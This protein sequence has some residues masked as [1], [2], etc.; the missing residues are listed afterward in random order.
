MG[1]SFKVL[2]ATAEASPL[3]KVGGLGDV[4]GSLP[5]ALR[6]LG[7]D[8]RIIMPRYGITNLE[9]HQITWRGNLNM[10]FMGDGEDTGISE[11]LLRDGTPVYLVENKRY[12]D[13]PAVYGEADDLERFLLFSLAVME[14]PKILGWHPDI[15]HCHDWHTGMVPARLKAARR[16]DP[17]YSSCASVYTIHNLGYQGWFDDGFAGRAGIYDYLPPEGDP[18]RDRAY[19]MTAIGIYHG[20]IISTVSET[21]AVE[22]LTPE[23]GMGLETLLE[24]RRDSLFG[25]LNG[26]DYEE[27]NPAL[28]RIIAA[29]YDAHTLERKATNKL[30]VQEKAGLPV[31][32]GTP[33][34]GLAA[35]LVDQ[36]GIDIL[37]GALDSLF[38]EADVQFVLQ[39]TGEPR[40][41]ESLRGLQDRYP[42]KA[43]TFLVLDFSLARLIFAGCDIYLSPSRFEPCG[44]SHLIAMHYGAIPVVR[45]TGGLAETV[46]DCNSD[47]SA[48][49][50]FVFESYGQNDLLTA[51]RRAVATFQRKEVWHKLVSRVMQVDFSW[52]SSAPKYASLYQRARRKVVRQ[53]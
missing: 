30:A 49:L 40:Y 46:P 39:G 9:G 52:K 25:I 12:F 48:G 42:A 33:L 16:D 8:V 50:G 15:L 6:R 21:Y 19:S 18:L 20:D 22:I 37:V 35:R 4:A 43:R 28:D 27:F 23:Y 1:S 51:L 47:P 36:K 38:G 32:A 41:E 3:I 34:L 26:I 14:T 53:E 29:N 17:F 11:V 44:L 5:R 31:D 13:R 2:F 7:H 10:P 24:S 45:R